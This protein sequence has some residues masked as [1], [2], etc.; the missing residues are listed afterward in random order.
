VIGRVLDFGTVIIRGTGG[1]E[2]P[3]QTIAH[4][5]EFRNCVQRLQSEA[6]NEQ[7]AI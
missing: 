7:R 1:S 5:L 2:E 3:F 6:A 4:P